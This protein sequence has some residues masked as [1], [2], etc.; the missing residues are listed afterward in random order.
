MHKIPSRVTVIGLGPAWLCLNKEKVYSMYLTAAEFAATK[1]KI[2]K[3]N[4]RAVKRGWT[5]TITVIGEKVTKSET[6]PN[7]L[8]V[9]QEFIDTTITGEP[10]RYEDY[11]FLAKLEWSEDSGLVVFSAP[12]AP[13]LDRSNLVEGA[14]DHCK[15]NR[16]RKHVYVVADESGKMIQVGSTCLK[17]FLGWNVNPV[18]IDD[19]DVSEDALFGDG[20]YGH[21]EPSYS[22]EIVLAAAWAT[23]QEFGYVRSGE[24]GSTRNTVLNVLNPRS[25]SD[26]EI[27]DQVT[28]HIPDATA[29]AKM[30]REWVLSDAFNGHS[31]YVYN[32]KNIAA[33][34]F[35]SSRNFGFLVSA[36]QAWAKAMERDLIHRAEKAEVLNEWNGQPGDKLEVSVTLKSI[37]AIESDWGSSDLYTFEGTDKRIYKWFSTRVIFREVSGEVINIKGTVKKHD[38]YKGVKATV[39]TRVKVV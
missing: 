35:V 17:D 30:I 23:I 31:D 21:T 8:T 37:R 2:S 9:T 13:T 22:T 4:A 12:G 6:L 24:A 3:L 18:W 33:G 25:K 26:R 38:E 39:L 5:G 14:C 11:T 20:G 36:P 10:P 27:R 32:L 19:S 1:D 15:I 29:H 28:P 7:G 16:Y 34:E